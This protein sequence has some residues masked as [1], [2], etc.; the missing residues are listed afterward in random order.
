MDLVQTQ[1][2]WIRD[3]MRW[4]LFD[5][6]ALAGD[7]TVLTREMTAGFEKP[8][9]SPDDDAPIRAEEG[10]KRAGASRWSVWLGRVSNIAGASEV[11][12]HPQGAGYADSGALGC[13]CR[14]ACRLLAHK[15]C[16]NGRT[17]H[18]RSHSQPHVDNLRSQ[19]SVDEGCKIERYRVQIGCNEGAR[20][21]KTLD[22][23]ERRGFES[24]RSASL[25]S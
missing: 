19:D 13:A 22:P 12:E 24:S 8:V 17:I 3:A 20:P 5:I 11:L 4:P 15:V 1:Q 14:E 21:Q 23:G 6:R 10:P 18:S 2:D 25:D 7:T 9:G 16:S